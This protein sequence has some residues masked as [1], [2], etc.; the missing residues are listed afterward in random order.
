[1]RILTEFINKATS[2]EYYLNCVQP[3]KNYVSGWSLGDTVHPRNIYKVING[4]SG[5]DYAKVQHCAGKKLTK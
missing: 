1:M 3:F 5:K 2:G 4:F